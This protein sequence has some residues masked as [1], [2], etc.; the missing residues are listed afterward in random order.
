MKVLLT[1]GAGYIGSHTAVELITAGHEVVVLDNLSNSSVTAVRRVERLTNGTIA[2]H[3]VDLLAPPDVEDVFN[4]HTFDAVIHFAGLKAV[5]ESVSKPLEY[6][7]TN[8]VGTLNLLELML[9]HHVDNLVFSSSATVYGDPERIPLDE[10]CRVVDATNPYARTK[11]MLEKIIEDT[12]KANPRLNVARLRYFNPVGAHPSGEIGEDPRDIPNNLMPFVTQV[13]VGKR[14][15][16][17]VFGDDY[18][19]DDGT[20]IR[21]YIHVVDLAQGHLAALDMLESKPGLVTYNLGTGRGYSVLEVIRAFESATGVSVPFEI[22]ARRPGDLPV[23]FTKTDKAADELGWH[24]TRGIV[25]ICRDAW[26]W[27][28]RNPNG[29]DD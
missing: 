23:S 18:P 27:Q 15:K 25:D 11:L 29:Y 26:N 1:G 6:Y 9:R 20:C 21:D 7:R 19:T 28:S 8:I 14:D 24:A 10:D 16:L 12:C 5:G 22:G 17:V 4:Q 3:E 2:F 13:A